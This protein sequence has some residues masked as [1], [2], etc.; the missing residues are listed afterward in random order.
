[1]HTD[2]ARYAMQAFGYMKTHVLV[3]S[4][5]DPSQIGSGYE[6]SILDVHSNRTVQHAW[7]ESR[8]GPT[9]SKS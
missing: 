5:P 3:V 1:M 4:F 2:S 7:V 9:G 6:T 8:G